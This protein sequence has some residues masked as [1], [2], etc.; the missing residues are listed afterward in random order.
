MATTPEI[1]VSKKD[2]TISIIE[3]M[4]KCHKTLYSKLNWYENYNHANFKFKE[5]LKVVT[6]PDYLKYTVEY[7]SGSTNTNSAHVRCLLMNFSAYDY[8]INNLK[9][10]INLAKEEAKDDKEIFI[11]Y[12]LTTYCTC[13]HTNKHDYDSIFGHIIKKFLDDSFNG[14]FGSDRY[15]GKII[16]D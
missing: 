13:S 10:I 2:A 6:Y 7:Y 1:T 12:M 8:D 11:K 3:L 15:K 16:L 4:A 9:E 5:G 14:I